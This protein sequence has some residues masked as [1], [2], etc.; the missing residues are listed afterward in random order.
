MVVNIRG[1]QLKD[2]D[3][4]TSSKLKI[5]ERVDEGTFVGF[6]SHGIP[7]MDGLLL[8]NPNLRWMI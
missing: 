2:S 6:H 1:S 4:K 8:E 7:K 5:C 3:R